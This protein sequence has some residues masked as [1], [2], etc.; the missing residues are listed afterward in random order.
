MNTLDKIMRGEYA[1]DHQELV[2]KQECNETVKSDPESWT[3]PILK[4]GINVLV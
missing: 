3:E 1:D 2:V 4:P